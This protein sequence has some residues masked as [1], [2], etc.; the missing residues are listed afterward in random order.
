MRGAKIGAHSTSNL[1]FY[2]SEAAITKLEREAKIYEWRAFVEVEGGGSGEL[3]VFPLT[4]PECAWIGLKIGMGPF[5][6]YTH[7]ASGL[8]FWWRHLWG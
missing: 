5:W 1:V 8:A 7:P 2:R 4:C 6:T 3:N